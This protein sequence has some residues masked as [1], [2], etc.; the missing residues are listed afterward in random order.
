[1]PA[2]RKRSPSKTK[3]APSQMPAKRSSSKAKKEPSRPTFE[4]MTSSHMNELNKPFWNKQRNQLRAKCQ[5]IVLREEVKAGLRK[6]RI[7]RPS[8][9][10]YFSAQ[11]RAEV[12]AAHPR[13]PV[14]EVAKELGKEWHSLS[15]SQKEGWQTGANTAARDARLS[16]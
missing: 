7:P 10:L 13:W 6:P 9:F 14:T 16:K 4:A 8:G 11:K 5:R 15:A 3:K 12:L 2:K 1:M